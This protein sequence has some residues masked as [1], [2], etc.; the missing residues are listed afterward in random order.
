MKRSLDEEDTMKTTTILVPVAL[1]AAWTVGAS[2]TVNAQTERRRPNTPDSAVVALDAIVVSVTRT[3]TA[4]RDVPANVTVVT[5]ADIEATS[6]QSLPDLLHTIPGFTLKDYQSSTVSH[7]TRQ[8]PTLRGLGGG[9]SATRVL[10]LV[11][12]VPAADPFAGWVHWARIPL[13]LVERIEIVR[14]GGSGIWGS[15]AMGGVINIITLSPTTSMA[16]IS[17]QGGSFGTRRTDLAGTWRSNRLTLAATGSLFETDGYILVDPALRGSIDTP[18]GSSHRTAFA[19]LGWIAH[20]G[21][22]LYADASHLDEDRGADTPYRNNGVDIT[23]A[24]IGTRFVTGANDVD[25]SAFYASQ[26]FHMR[27]SSESADRQTEIPSLDQFDVPT[28]SAGASLVWSN[29][30]LARHT[31]TAGTDW[32]RIDGDV[33]EEYF[34][35]NDAYRIRRAVGGV[36]TLGGV[37]VQDAFEPFDRLHLLASARIDYAGTSD[38]SRREYMIDSGNTIR[39]TAY[40][41]D[42]HTPFNFSLGIRH[43]LSERLSWRS[44]VYRAFRAPTLNELYKPFREPGNIV[45]ESTPSLRPERM[46]GFE[47]G[48]DYSLGSTLVRF[49]AFRTTIHD[50]IV[51]ATVEQAGS[52]GRNIAPCGF[53]PAG[54]VCKERRNVPAYR[55]AGIEA[56]VETRPTSHVGLSASVLW[57]PTEVVSAD[58]NPELVGKQGSRTPRYAV[59][60]SA[61]YS[62][63]TLID[64]VLSARWVGKRYDDDLNSLE[65]RPFFVLDARVGRQFG[66]HLELFGAVENVLDEAYPVT[67]AQS[68][69]VRLGGPRTFLAGLRVAT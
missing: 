44:S 69:L 49:T 37:F 50:L 27:F 46:T 34:W 11:D 20:D 17:Q 29:R 60:A 5:K 30:S 19:K 58:D 59:S 32:L 48:A 13:E 66:N 21:V 41:S 36:Q 65:L 23:Q 67:R 14:G 6:A 4:V 64:A 26:T 24:R 43:E 55:A 61:R 38:A 18:S 15:R 68:G 42:S 9:T 33:N 12:G 7:P 28:T 52:A 3:A 35:Q 51:E 54:G 16:R 2:G 25:V 56:E 22:T 10:V 62:N 1:A 31:L 53:V 63:P 39:D 47:I 45:V 40:A 8:A 57:N